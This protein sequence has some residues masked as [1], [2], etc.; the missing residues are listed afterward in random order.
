MHGIPHPCVV[1][2]WE[3]NM[4]VA[5]ERIGLRNVAVTQNEQFYTL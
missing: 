1:S 2:P 5:T 4:Q 3:K